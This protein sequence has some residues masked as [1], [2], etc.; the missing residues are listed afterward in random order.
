MCVFLFGVTSGLASGVWIDEAIHD[1]SYLTIF[2]WT[3]CVISINLEIQVHLLSISVMVQHQVY[4]FCTWILLFVVEQLTIGFGFSIKSCTIAI[5]RSS[6]PV[7]MWKNQNSK[8]EDCWTRTTFIKRTS[9]TSISEEKR[10]T[11]STQKRT[12]RIIRLSYKG[13]KK[14]KL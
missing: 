1:I 8:H 2:L 10:K 11:K 9:L 3:T 5:N 7:T 14:S 13:R 12:G 6:T 4:L